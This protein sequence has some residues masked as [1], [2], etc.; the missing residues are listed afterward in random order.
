MSKRLLFYQR[1]LCIAMQTKNTNWETRRK[2]VLCLFFIVT[3]NLKK[4]LKVRFARCAVN[5]PVMRFLRFS[6]K[7]QIAMGDFQFPYGSPHYDTP[8]WLYRAVW[9]Y[10]IL[11]GFWSWSLFGLYFEFMVFKQGVRLFRRGRYL[12]S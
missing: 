9:E 1:F 11:Y 6:E 8:E 3:K 7:I 10:F 12:I 4:L 5:D 2:L